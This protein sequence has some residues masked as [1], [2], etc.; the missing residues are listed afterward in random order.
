MTELFEHLPGKQENRPEGHRRR[1]NRRERHASRRTRLALL[2]G[3]GLLVMLVA[4]GLGVKVVRPLLSNVGSSSDYSGDGS[5]EVRFKVA[6]GESGAQ[7]AQ[8]LV[9]QDVIKSVDAFNTAAAANSKSASIQPGTYRLKSQMSAASA[10]SALL[11]KQNRVSIQVTLPEGLRAA[12]ALK[13]ISSATGFSVEALRAAAKD[14]SVGLPAAAKGNLEGYLFPATYSLDPSSKP[15]SV[16]QEILSAYRG[17][18]KTAGV[19]EGERHKVLT[20]ASIVQGE[21][22]NT[23]EMPKISRVFLNR[24]EKGMPLQSDFTV[25]YAN[26]VAGQLTTTDAMRANPSPY[27][28][29]KHQGLPPGPVDS[30]GLAAIKAAYKPAAG[31]W[32]Y[33]VAVNP[34]TGETRFATT[35]AEHDQNVKLLQKWLQAH[36]GSGGN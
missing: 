33:F 18:M 17:A 5:G 7:I 13:R 22:G 15:V 30:P 35:K 11:D 4:L 12:D 2:V 25:L 9:K 23:A 29:Y 14:P 8:S 26:K 3:S 6:Q 20:L 31:S 16:M 19:P 10:L 1:E 36:P 21:A 27:N 28:T 24:I 32:L 34:E